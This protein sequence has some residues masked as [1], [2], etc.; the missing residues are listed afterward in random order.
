MNLYI[1]MLIGN[2][3][4]G[5]HP[6]CMHMACLQHLVVLSNLPE[7]ALGKR[8]IPSVRWAHSLDPEKQS[9]RTMRVQ[10]LALVPRAH[11]CSMCLRLRL[12]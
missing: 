3:D 2:I 11:F 7:Y 4:H 6:W 8:P 10:P 5:A 1:L 9:E 12:A